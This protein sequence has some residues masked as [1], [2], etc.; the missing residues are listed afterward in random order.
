[1]IRSILI[2]TRCKFRRG[3]SDAAIYDAAHRR[4][5]DS[6]V[7]A[8]AN[9]LPEYLL[10]ADGMRDLSL[11][12]FHEES[13]EW[14]YA[15]LAITKQRYGVDIDI[16]DLLNEP[17]FQRVT[18]DV[19]RQVFE[20][21]VP[22][23]QHLVDLH[24]DT[25]GVEMPLISGPS[26]L[27]MAKVS[28]WL[29]NWRDSGSAA[30]DHVDIMAGHP[31]HAG[32]NPQ[33]YANAAALRD[34]DH[35]WFIQNEMEFGHQAFVDNG[36]PYPNDDLENDWEGALA[37][38][39]AFTIATDEGANGFHV[40]QG[41]SPVSGGAKSLIRTPWGE[42]AVRR[43][44]YFVYRQLTSLQPLGSDVVASEA[45]GLPEGVH[46][47]AF[48]KWGD[49]RV[50]VTI[51]NANSSA[52]ET[53]TLRFKDAEGNLI[54]FR[55]IVDYETNGT[56]DLTINDTTT[57]AT[58]VTQWSTVVQPNSVRTFEVRLTAMGIPA[59]ESTYLRER[60]AFADIPQDGDRVPQRELLLGLNGNGT[61]G[62]GRGRMR[63]LL[64]FDLDA[65]D[66]APYQTISHATLHLAAYRG[67]LQ[68]DDRLQFALHAFASEF[69]ATS[70]TWVD[71][72]GDGNVATGD[73]EPGGTLG[74]S[75]GVSQIFDGS[76][77]DYNANGSSE[78]FRESL[79]FGP[80][81]DLDNYLNA[82]DQ[83]RVFFAVEPNDRVSTSGTF[84]GS[85]RK[86]PSVPPLRRTW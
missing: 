79:F 30:W 56:K 28:D 18:E 62:S 27:N 71:P 4:N 48:N 11:P 31:Y 50:F 73:P 60:P 3:P 19:A 2:S 21:T 54:P 63:G 74:A 37:L 72:D 40:F 26:N 10:D 66:L 65:W 8:Y 67:N 51:T 47:V 43:K 61:N 78:K 69:E 39:R 82:A 55:S 13:A 64:E 5:P 15:N 36:N 77:S 33:A 23:L 70:A 75:L 16:V 42:P 32:F 53:A 59:R 29:G 12:H 46:T 41:V 57:F 20:F 49:A 7:M 76:V 80:S 24:F 25:Y 85:T 86:I 52:T 9:R 44:G 84:L 83:G 1:M 6:L 35:P 58:P 81:E 14:L 68:N 22:A 17:D 34:V 38:A 45:A